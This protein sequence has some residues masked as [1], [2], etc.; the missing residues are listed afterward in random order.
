MTGLRDQR[1]SPAN[2]LAF[3][4]RPPNVA[5][6][7]NRLFRFFASDVLSQFK[8]C[9]PRSLFLRLTERFANG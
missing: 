5:C 1:D 3:G 7:D 6:F 2:R 8:M 4:N 9:R